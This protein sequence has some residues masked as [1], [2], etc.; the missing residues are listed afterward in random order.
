MAG[1][2]IHKGILTVLLLYGTSCQEAMV[3]GSNELVDIVSLRVMSLTVPV[4]LIERVLPPVFVTLYE[5]VLLFRVKLSVPEY[6]LFALMV[7]R[8]TSA[9]A[10]TNALA[11]SEIFKLALFLMAQKLLVEIQM[12]ILKDTLPMMMT[13]NNVEKP[14]RLSYGSTGIKV[15]CEG[16]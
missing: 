7:S 11:S 8:A 10:F 5:Q 4:T 1:I 15:L 14:P 12:A 3:S 16:V 6:E 13:A 9:H 2:C